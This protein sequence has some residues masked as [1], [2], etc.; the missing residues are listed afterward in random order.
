[1]GA[2]LKDQLSHA[3][4]LIYGI[5]LVVVI[6]YMPD[7]ILGFIRKITSRKRAEAA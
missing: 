7:G 6:L 1:V 4:V 3:H 2:F 5:L